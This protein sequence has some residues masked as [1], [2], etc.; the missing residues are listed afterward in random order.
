M[1]DTTTSADAAAE[2]AAQ[3]DAAITRAAAA[4]ITLTPGDFDH[5]GLGPTLDGMSV[6]DWLTAMTLP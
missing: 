3:I 2:L 4:G 1:N 5:D 6:D